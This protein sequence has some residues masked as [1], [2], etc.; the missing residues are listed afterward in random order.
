MVALL[1]LVNLERYKLNYAVKYLFL[2]SN[3]HTGCVSDWVKFSH[4]T[5]YVFVNFV[6]PSFVASR[7]DFNQCYHSMELLNNIKLIDSYY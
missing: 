6:E 3:F 5:I 1:N 2:F 7:K 4:I